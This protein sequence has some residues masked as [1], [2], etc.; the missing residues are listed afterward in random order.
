MR[1]RVKKVQTKNVRASKVKASAQSKLQGKSGDAPTRVTQLA[2][3]AQ[4]IAPGEEDVTH[5]VEFLET[6]R[7]L[8]DP[9][10]QKPAK[11]ISI[12]IP[13]Q[14]L[15][16]FRFKAERE[17]KRYQTKIKELMLEYVRGGAV[18]KSGRE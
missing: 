1:K 9:R 12:K 4:I 2:S 14:L 18:Y 3:D 6:F 11:L 15:T 7:E 17:N 10:A 13:E 8:A 5:I 16:T